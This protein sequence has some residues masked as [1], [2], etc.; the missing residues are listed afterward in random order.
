MDE[1]NSSP[2]AFIGTNTTV[3]E[4]EPHTSLSPIVPAL[5]FAAGAIGNMTALIVLFKSKKENRRTIFYRLVGLLAIVDLFGTISTSPV[6]FLQYAH[7][8]HWYGGD[9]LCNY[10]SFMLIFSGLSTMFVVAIMALDRYIALMHPYF[11]AGFVTKRKAVYILSSLFIFSIAISSLPLIGVGK[12]VLHYPGTWCFF[13]FRSEDSTGKAF[14]YIYSLTGI[15]IIVLITASNVAVIAT[16][17]QMR[18]TSKTISCNK[19]EICR[20]DR[21]MQMMIFLIAVVLIFIICWAPLMVVVLLCTTGTIKHSDELDLLVIR[22]ASFNQILDPWAY[23]LL[24]KRHIILCIRWTGKVLRSA[25]GKLALQTN[26]SNE[27]PESRPLPKI[28]VS[29]ISHS[30]E[31]SLSSSFRGECTKL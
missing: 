12:N 24:K 28:G 18:D 22:L 5:M 4:M 3:L 14:T 25:R 29:D 20:I 10:F 9:H 2:S 19:D 31:K 6:T 23:I 15:L 11:Y 8:P 13:D 30:F 27:T 16:L 1:S 17:I 7:F 21:E 26:S